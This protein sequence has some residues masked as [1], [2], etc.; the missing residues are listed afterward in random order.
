[1]GADLSVRPERSAPI[2]FDPCSSA[3]SHQIHRK[4]V[5]Q[6]NASYGVR[7]S[8]VVAAVI[9]TVMRVVLPSG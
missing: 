9:V 7:F 2:S 4:Q 3:A 8:G 1:M 6:C 5:R